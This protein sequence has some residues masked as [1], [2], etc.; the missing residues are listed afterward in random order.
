MTKINNNQDFMN[1]DYFCD[2]VII[3]IIEINQ[4]SKIFFRDLYDADFT[5]DCIIET[6]VVANIKEINELI[7]NSSM[8]TDLNRC[9][10]LFYNTN[11]RFNFVKQEKKIISY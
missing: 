10:T 9:P 1:Y 3:E 5:I 4:K 11:L 2:L 7:R 6:T 8:K